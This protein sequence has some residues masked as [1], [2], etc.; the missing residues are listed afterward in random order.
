MFPS[1]WLHLLRSPRSYY[2][3]LSDGS[4]WNEF[5]GEPKITNSTKASVTSLQ[6]HRPCLGSFGS[7]VQLP[8]LAFHLERTTAGRQVFSR[9]GRWISRGFFLDLPVGNGDTG[10]WDVLDVSPPGRVDRKL[11]TRFS[12]P[13]RNGA[14]E[15]AWTA[16]KYSIDTMRTCKKKMP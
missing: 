6:P 15:S 16:C 13:G 11:K 1:W 8:R 3:D 9:F 5:T 4:S 12:Y 2:G 10:G 7:S 14:R